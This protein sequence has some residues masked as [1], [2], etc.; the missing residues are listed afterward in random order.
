M[1]FTFSPEQQHLRKE[2]RAVF[3]RL[4]TPEVKAELANGD[5]MGT[6]YRAFVRSLG[7]EGWLGVGW[8]T[9]YGGRGF[10]PVEQSIFFEEAQRAEAPLPLV[11]LNTVGPTLMQ[12]GSEEQKRQFLPGILRGDVE[13]AIGY[14]E[15]GSGSDLASLRTR[16]IRDGDNYVINGNK[17][18]TSGVACADYVWLAVRTDPDAPK[19]KG[20]SILIVPVSSPGLSWSPIHTMPGV[21]TYASYYND[22]RVPA[23]SIV[24]GENEG[25]KL[26]MAQLNFERAFLGAIGALEPLFDA[27]IQW[28]RSAVRDGRRV[29]EEP[30]VQAVLARVEANVEAYRLLNQRMAWAMTDGAFSPAEAS[31]VKVFGTELTQEAARMMLQVLGSEGVRKGDGAALHGRLERAYRLAVLNT[32]GGGANEIQ[33]DIIAMMGLRL[34]R[35]P[36]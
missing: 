18:F 12:F 10:T 30:W 8:P 23:S 11:T 16:A 33:R 29:I 36:R 24:A 17:I 28:A 15:P 7:A 14:S 26:I 5:E 4:M 19:H 2:I 20:I 27:T 13:F 9:E 35:S 6:A 21:T 32:F 34:P 1:E 31:A 25:W 22:V 3:E